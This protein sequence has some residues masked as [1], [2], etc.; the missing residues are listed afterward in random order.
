MFHQTI[1]DVE[2]RLAG[3]QLKLESFVLTP[4]SFQS[5]AVQGWKKEDWQARNVV[6]MQ[7]NQYLSQLMGKLL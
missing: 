4:T 5:I 1:K 6:F 3:K 2:Q 7:D